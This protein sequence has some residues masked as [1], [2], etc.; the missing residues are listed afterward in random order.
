MPDLDHSAFAANT[1]FDKL[2]LAP[3]K[4]IL[5]GVAVLILSLV[6]L[7]WT[8]Q[9]EYSLG[10]LYVLPMLLGG[11]TLNRT[12][13]VALALLCAFARGMFTVVPTQLD[14]V[15][16]FLMATLA[17]CGAGLF[18]VELRRNRQLYITHLL[19]IEREEQLRRV[20]ED[21]LRVLVES[22]PAAIMTIDED[23]KILAAN[24][25]ASELLGLPGSQTLLGES[26]LSYIP[27]FSGV[28][29]YDSRDRPLRT[30]S[31]CWGKR[32]DGSSFLAQTWFSTY[33]SG[34]RR[35]LAAIAVDIS[36]DVRNR[37][38][39]HLAQISSNN[40]VLAGALS[41]EIRNL[42]AALS[43]VW[44]NLERKGALGTDADF[45][46]LHSLVQA[47]AQLA[48]FELKPKVESLTYVSIPELLKR[49][50]VIAG[51]S[52]D[53]ID[54]H[55]QVHCSEGIPSAL[56]DPHE[57]LQVL[58]NLS[59]NSIRAVANEPVRNFIITVT[60]AERVVRLTFQDSGPGI[61]DSSQL[62][63]AFQ[64]RAKATGLGL[65]VSRAL[66]R[67]FGGEL[68]YQPGQAGACFVLELLQAQDSSSK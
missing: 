50:L 65:Y 12:Q 16:R 66:A 18:T 38:E 46:A 47:L 67:S 31:Q 20:A 41:H 19:Q 62:F 54:G 34:D 39:R 4:L 58:L 33:V 57:L 63:H 60:A 48:S 56:G 64:D 49:F 36:E 40:R 27:V 17:Y 30:A 51:E 15:L 5:A 9:I 42:C 7:E 8:L 61:A 45:A 55:I 53:E 13:I 52:W 29:R 26:I 37:E 22:S 68:T 25:A 21:H 44:S 28:L 43:V 2:L 23:G 59:Q 32:R 24:Y 1:P 6:A 3:R 14:Y 10:V 11:I 35:R